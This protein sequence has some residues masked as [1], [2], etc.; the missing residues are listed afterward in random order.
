MPCSRHYTHDWTECPF[1]H[2]G[3]KATRRD[4][5]L[6]TYVGIDC[7]HIKGEVGLLWSCG[8]GYGLLCSPTS[9]HGETCVRLLTT[10]SNAGCIHQGEERNENDVIDV[11]GIG[12]KCAMSRLR[13]VVKFVSLR[14]LVK[15]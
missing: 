5:R 14:I 7:P 3:E 2:P 4:P 11:I 15:K 10:C 1:A 9:V 6:F 8:Y 13:V 12:H